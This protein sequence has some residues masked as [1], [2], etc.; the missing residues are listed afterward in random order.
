MFPLTRAFLCLDDD[1]VFEGGEVCPR[2][3]GRY[4]VPIGRWLNRPFVI[5]PREA[6]EVARSPRTGRPLKP[7]RSKIPEA[8]K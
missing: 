1:T 2:C 3:A 6:V 5:S 4:V 7:N 8:A